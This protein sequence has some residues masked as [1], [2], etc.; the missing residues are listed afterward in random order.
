MMSDGQ[1]LGPYSGEQM[2]QYAAEGR[3][4]PDSLVWAE[5]MAEWA[6][7]SQVPG[8]LPQAAA[9]PAAAAAAKPAWAPPGARPATTASPYTTPQSSLA[10]APVGGNYPMLS[11]KPASFGL[12]MWTFIGSLLCLLLA[13]VFFGLGV[14]AAAS[15]PPPPTGEM[16]TAGG[17]QMMLGGIMYMIFFPMVLVSMI[18]FMMNIYRAW[19][20]LLAGNPSTTPG[21]A[22][23]FM[24]IPFFNIYWIF[25][26]I[27]GLPKDWN[28]I[29][30][31]YEDLHTAP[32]MSEGVFLMYAIGSI[33]FPPLSL[34]V[35]FPMMSQIC[36]GINFFAYRRSAST[37]G[38]FGGIKFG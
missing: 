8:L 38:G 25:V 28:R 12:W 7:A 35:M 32:R 4:A 17:P 10:A 5:G 1:Q 3:I 36:N 21:K 31:S 29:V 27:A 30:S 22:V 2:Q 24:F 9:Q 26:A 6:Q 19:S 20:C 37:T 23:G 13:I 15:A 18:F 34:V 33:I 16:P 11:V 14:S